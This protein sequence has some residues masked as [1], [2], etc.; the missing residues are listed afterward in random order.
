MTVTPPLAAVE[1]MDRDAAAD[2]VLRRLIAHHSGQLPWMD[3]STA[4]MRMGEQDSHPEVQ[5]FARHRIEALSSQDERAT[6][7][8]WL[9]HVAHWNSAAQLEEAAKAIAK[10]A[11]A[12]ERGDHLKGS[13]K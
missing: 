11:G 13:P 6:I 1:Q 4:S 7:V 9:R 3:A 12:I 5:A 8:A 10:L 2:S